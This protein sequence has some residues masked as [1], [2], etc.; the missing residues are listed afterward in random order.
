MAAEKGSEIM[1]SQRKQYSAEQ[2]ARIALEA[3]KG[4]RTVNE[5]AGSYGIHPSQVM[6]WKKQLTDGAAQL[7]ESR[8]GR[9]GSGEEPETAVLYQHIGQLQ[10][11]PGWLKKKS[12][13][14]S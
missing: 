12:G 1:K 3:I 9:R 4:Q 6:T 5:I 10:V 2:K 14:G 7:F 8:R 11:E 13:I